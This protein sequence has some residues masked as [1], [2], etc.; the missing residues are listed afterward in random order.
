METELKPLLTFGPGPIRI[1]VVILEAYIR[2]H[3]T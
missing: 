3:H 2:I 1:S